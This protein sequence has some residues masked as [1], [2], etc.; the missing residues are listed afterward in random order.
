MKSVWIFPSH[1]KYHSEN[2]FGQ[3]HQVHLK[4]FLP[5]DF[6]KMRVP[7]LET[8]DCK[9]HLKYILPA[10]HLFIMMMRMPLVEIRDHEVHLKYIL[11]AEYIMMKVLWVDIRAHEERVWT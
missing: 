6:L 11:L 3:Y 8:R 10:E 9:V 2:A 4:Y 7:L 1:R 5:A